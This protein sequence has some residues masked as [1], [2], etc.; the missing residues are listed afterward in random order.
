MA[1]YA[2]FHWEKNLPLCKSQ[3]LEKENILR[4]HLDSTLVNAWL[5]EDHGTQ[6]FGVNAVA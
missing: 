6:K 4:Y 1:Y 3:K 5:K 2:V